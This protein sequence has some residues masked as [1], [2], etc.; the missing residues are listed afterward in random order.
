M[1]NLV[2]HQEIQEMLNK[3]INVVVKRGEEIKEQ[4]L[5]KNAIFRGHSVGDFKKTSTRALHIAMCRDRGHYDRR[6]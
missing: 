1:A 4:D 6:L 3:E 2:K 5:E